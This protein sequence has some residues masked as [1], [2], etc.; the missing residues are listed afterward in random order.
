MTKFLK[1]LYEKIFKIDDTPQKIA[2]GFGLG[3]FVGILPGAGPLAALFLSFIFRV[4]RASALAASL[5][6]NAWLS[7][8][9][10]ILSIK[11]GS[12]ILGLDWHKVYGDFSAKVSAS[13]W[14]GFFK[15]SLLKII[16]PIILGYLII[17]LCLGLIAYLIVLFIINIR[18]SKR[19]K[20]DGYQEIHK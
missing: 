11:A 18:N 15:L 8:A 12:A 5:L 6:T 7:V 3:V 1:I 19:R 20:Q 10:F 14:S 9:T 16:L 2:V 4:N 13:N 17:S